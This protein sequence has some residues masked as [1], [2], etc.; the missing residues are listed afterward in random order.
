MRAFIRL[1]AITCVILAVPMSAAAADI[2]IG[3][4]NV[5]EIMIKSKTG[6][7]A[8]NQLKA[9]FE[10]REK[11]LQAQGQQIKKAN[12]DLMKQ[13]GLLSDG[14]SAPE[15]DG[16][17]SAAAKYQQDM[18]KYQEDR[19]NEENNA[20][21]PLQKRMLEVTAAYAQKNGFTVILDAA[22]VPYFAAPLDVTEAVK[23]AFDKGK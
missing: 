12:D 22:T 2:K 23:A 6:S 11:Q 15:T 19:V 8:F 20:L 10:A 17:A 21:G 16:N 13:S 4:I 1:L 3:V 9:K 5:Q 18:Q 14:T 7:Q